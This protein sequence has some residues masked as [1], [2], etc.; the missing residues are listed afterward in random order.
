MA[1]SSSDFHQD[2]LNDLVGLG[3]ITDPAELE[4]LEGEDANRHFSIVSAALRKMKEE[5]E[6]AQTRLIEAAR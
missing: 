3:Y 1:Y 6:E 5:R 2:T 4:E